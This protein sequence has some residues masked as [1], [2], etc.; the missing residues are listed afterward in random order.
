MFD[1]YTRPLPIAFKEVERAPDVVGQADAVHVMHGLGEPDR[2]RSVLRRLDKS[3]KLG[4][5][6]DQPAAIEDRCGPRFR[7]TRLPIRRAIGRDCR[8][9]ARSPARTR[10]E[11]SRP[12]R[13]N[14]WHEC[15]GVNR[16]GA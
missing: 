16:S 4:E 5:A 14:S 8:C 15:G 10:P 2:L 12:A 9:P 7:T 11:G 3:T 13:A 1:E 6:P